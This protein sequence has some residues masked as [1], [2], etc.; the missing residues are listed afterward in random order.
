MFRSITTG[1]D[2]DIICHASE[3]IT[4]RGQVNG[5]IDEVCQ[6]IQHQNDTAARQ[7]LERIRLRC[8]LVDYRHDN[9]MIGQSMNDVIECPRLTV[10]GF[11][12]EYDTLT[13]ADLVRNL[14]LVPSRTEATFCNN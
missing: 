11:A 8:G 1:C 9:V 13:L 4:K 3:S 14:L 5:G 2:D 12:E 7:N 6:V 10:G